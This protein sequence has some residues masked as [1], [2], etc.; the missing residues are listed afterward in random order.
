MSNRYEN[1]RYNNWEYDDNNNN[2][3]NNELD[4]E[5][6][7][8]MRKLKH[9]LPRSKSLSPVKLPRM[10]QSPTRKMMQQHNISPTKRMIQRKKRRNTLLRIIF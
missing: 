7:I 1:G 9:Y 2:N 6:D 5:Y 3:F 4:E 10:R 8:M